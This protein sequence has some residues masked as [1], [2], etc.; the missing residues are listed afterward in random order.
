MSNEI[1]SFFTFKL[2]ATQYFKHTFFFQSSFRFIF[3]W[4]KVIKR[5]HLSCTL[6][7][8][9]KH[10]FLFWYICFRCLQKICISFSSNT[11]FQE[12]LVIL[13]ILSAILLLGDVTYTIK[14]SSAAA[15]NPYL[16]TSG[17][18]KYLHIALFW[19]KL[20]LNQ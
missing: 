11:L 5:I 1:W 6:D 4:M 8:W 9:K 12:I 3:L 14:G 19:T 18:V 16:I 13:R 17:N 2:N 7:F 20:V 10:Y 15:N